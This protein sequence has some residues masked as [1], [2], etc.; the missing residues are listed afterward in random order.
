MNEGFVHK[1]MESC[2]IMILLVAK[3]PKNNDNSDKEI[4]AF[5][6]CRQ[7]EPYIY[8]D[9]VCAKYGIGKY[10]LGIAQYFARKTGG[11]RGVAFS[12]TRHALV[13]YIKSGFAPTLF[14][15]N[16]KCHLTDSLQ[17]KKRIDTET[18][19]EYVQ[20]LLTLLKQGFAT[21]S[22]RCK[23]LATNFIKS[24]SRLF[25]NNEFARAVLE[26][27]RAIN[28]ARDLTGTQKG[29]METLRLPPRVIED[30]REI[31]RMDPENKELLKKGDSRVVFG[32]LGECISFGF[33]MFRANGDTLFAGE[34]GDLKRV[35]RVPSD[36]FKRIPPRGVNR[37]PSDLF[38]R[39]SPRGVNRVPS[40]L[41][42]RISPRRREVSN[43]ETNPNS[44]KRRR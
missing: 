34:I 14:D 40:D 12:S 15:T 2:T 30:A 22:C 10:V 19:G 4:L 42:K 13:S 39:I 1:T 6:L 36:L 21:H 11:L 20:F 35:N 43:N 17:G 44:K 7:K 28:T 16:K 29:F 26:I 32:A 9:L 31:L 5:G 3:D 33:S 41:F 18:D 23:T 37:V 25:K 8:I 27:A 24:N 38:K